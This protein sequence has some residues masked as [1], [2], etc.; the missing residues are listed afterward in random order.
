MATPSTT[1]P[2]SNTLRPRIPPQDLDAERALLGAVMLRPEAMHDV[3]DIVSPD[4]FYGEKH[5]RIFDA[6]LRL[7]LKSEPIDLLS[8]ASRLKQDKRLEQI[9]GNTYLAELVNGV[10]A[11][12]NARH[13]A[14]LV[15]KAS[16]LRRLIEASEFIGELGFQEGEE[17]DSILERAEKKIYEITSTPSMHKFVELKNTLTEAWDR[18]DRLHKSKGELRGVPTGFPSLD[19]M[20]A[21]LQKSDLIIL[22]ARPSLGKTT[23]ALDIA[24]QSAVE[25]NIPVGIFSLEMG[26]QQL[27]DRL[28]AAQA[29]VDSWKLRTGKISGD[30][31]FDRIHDA[32]NTLSTAPIFIDDQPANNILAMRSVA[33]RLK[34]E[35]G[36][37]LLIVDYLQLMM[38]T[39]GRFLDS[40]VQQ[41]TEISRSL[42]AL[43]RELD[44]PI[45]ALS[46]LSRAIEQRRGR[47]R[48]SDLRDSGCL[49]GD[50]EVLDAKT[51]RRYTMLELAET[52]DASTTEVHVKST[53]HT[54]LSAPLS[55]AFYSGQKTVYRLTTK[56]GRSIKA[57]ANHPFLT[58]SGWRR[59]DELSLDESIATAR[60]LKTREPSGRM[61]DAELILLAH[62]LGDGCV[63]PRQPYHYTNAFDE[64]IETVQKS[65]HELFG[66]QGRVV[67]QKNWKH[68][69]LPSP[70]R[71]ARG[72]YHP[73][74]KWFKQL[75][76]NRVRPYEKEIPNEV[77]AVTNEQLA[78]FI[79]HLWST[80]GNISWKRSKGRKPSASIYFASSSRK[81]AEGLQT[82][83]LRLSI[84]GTLR[85][86]PSS[87][88]YRNMYH[89]YI[90]S[91][92]MQIRFLETVGIAD[93][94]QTM[95]KKLLEALRNI[96]PNPNTD[97]IPQTAWKEIITPAKDS[98]GISWRAF[99]AGLD[100]T[101][102]GSA[103]MATGISRSRMETIA[104]LLQSTECATLASSDIL[105]DKIASIESLGIEAVYDL[106]VPNHHNF[107][108]NN[109]LVHNSLEQ[110][111][112]VVMFIHRE[113]RMNE[114]SDRPNIAEII[115]EKHRN[116][117]LGKVE[118]YFDEKKTTFLSV[119]KSDFS[120]FEETTASEEV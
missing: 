65:A 11:A 54:L 105:W 66:I 43:A 77:F 117:P 62:L 88:G 13:Y 21:G 85:T 103:F 78:L 115:I 37:E 76:I 116:G 81:L 35:H 24:R 68:I 95:I 44:I 17:L 3:A 33:R 64:N 80:D 58:I 34:R 84:C 119:E 73:I 53:N 12:S 60:S 69:Y 89:V 74:T 82:L 32:M 22:A 55:R 49:S 63:L 1:Q 120:A 118:L 28:L 36:L 113:D 15:Q 10:P 4:A 6:M 91:N 86:V 39:S 111:A 96:V 97:I 40:M 50:T 98:L 5:K 72:K 30:D 79:R 112:D 114:N 94:R 26:S 9:G 57:S 59:L 27:V 46:Q 56:S 92:E 108:A 23:F 47:P 14:G 83:L 42:K 93:R 52:K 48:L 101:Y 100:N 61:K 16:V 7:F 31:E 51:G 20:L 75:G 18:L 41:V 109:I 104:K 107:I 110:D 70:Y 99:Q 2:I 19:N 45:L 87:K 25:H 102:N 90:E 106:T 38:P 67:A 29:R 8:V 71:L